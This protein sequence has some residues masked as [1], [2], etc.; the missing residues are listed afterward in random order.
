MTV[1]SGQNSCARRALA[2]CETALSSARLGRITMGKNVIEAKR[3]RRL[4]PVVFLEPDADG[5][6]D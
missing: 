5:V 1:T 4:G 6:N 2:L 3:R